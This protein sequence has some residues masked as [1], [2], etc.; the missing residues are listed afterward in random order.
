MTRVVAAAALA[1][2]LAACGHSGG[3]ARPA[4]T[5]PA[6]TAPATTPAP[7]TSPASGAHVGADF[8]TAVNDASAARS[9]SSG[10]LGAAT[11]AGEGTPPS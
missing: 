8:T 7:A 6:T 10:D 9:Q 11:A 1:L 2:A 4:P 5:T 3:S